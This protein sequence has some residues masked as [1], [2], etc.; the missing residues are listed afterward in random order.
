VPFSG[1]IMASRWAFEAL[2]VNQFM[3]NKFE[4]QFYAQDQKL[5]AAE[6]KKNYWLG[7]MRSKASS[8][9]N[10][11]NMAAE[12]RNEEKFAIDL[13]LLRRE[14]KKELET[15]GKLIPFEGVEKLQ[16]DQIDEVQLEEVKDYLSRLNEHYIGLYNKYYDL[17][18]QKIISKNRT[19]EDKDAF[20][21]LKDMYTNDALTDLVTDKN[22]FNK[23]LEMNGALYQKANPVYLDSKHFRSH[24]FA[25]YKRLF[26]NRISTYWANIMVL[27]L[28]SLTL[29]ITLN[30]DVLKK[31]IRSLEKLFSGGKR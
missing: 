9:Q 19:Q 2:A 3:N 14:I 15:T 5:K 11:L 21:Q 1:E 27:W 28:M 29:A 22:E 25:P 24:F 31:L 30:Y 7:K 12:E 10:S 8:C 17:K 6:F 13:Q 18:D 26:G 16:A 4:K 20:I 23:I